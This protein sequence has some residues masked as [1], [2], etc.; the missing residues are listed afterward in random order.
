MPRISKSWWTAIFVVLCA[1]AVFAGDEDRFELN[2]AKT[3]TYRG[4]RV[5]V[6]HGFGSVSVSAGSGNEVTIRATIR[7]SDPEFGKQI[8][9]ITSES[10]GITVKTEYPNRY[11]RRGNFSYSVDYR[12]TVPQNAPVTIRNRFGG[13]E[14][15]GLHAPSEFINSQGSVSL[16]NMQ[17]AQRVENAFGSIEVANAGPLTLKNANGSITARE[18]AGDVDATN[19][20]GSV[21]IMNAEDVTIRNAN[22]SVTVRDIKGSLEV[23]DSFASV[24]AI[25]VRGVADVTN[26]NGR[27]EVRNVGSNA[28]LATTFGSVVVSDVKGN[29]AVAA[30][31][32]RVEARTIGGNAT[33][34]TTFGNVD[35]RDITG[36][37]RVTN[38]N[39]G[40]TAENC[41]DFSAGT[42]F[43]SVNATRIRG[44]ADVENANGS[45]QLADVAREAKIRTSFGSAFVRGVGGMVD[46]QNQNGAIGVS[47]MRGGGCKPVTLKTSFSS[48]KVAV[49]QSANYAI[50]ARTSFGR[51][52]SALPITTTSLSGETVVGTIGSGG[53]H[54]ELIN[55]N[56]SITIER[57]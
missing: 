2:Y 41:G 29:L 46:I 6:D 30:Q 22:G 12:V 55:S 17:G 4:G 36:S 40:I 33:I 43:G 23:I 25:D 27:V 57:D 11:S 47:Q 19:R 3:F 50:S 35:A 38:Q 13:I 24:T 49:P 14:A 37:L 48:I 10:N 42:R 15:S 44:A 34:G 7:A 54:M 52:N 56:G 26:S 28:A 1:T 32:S 53:C 16:R 45:V 18:I 5:T 51:I 8:R 9:I 21:E 39:G 31:N 20:F